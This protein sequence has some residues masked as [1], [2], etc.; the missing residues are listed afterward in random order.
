MARLPHHR[1]EA[2]GAKTTG[3][4]PPIV[5]LR[6]GSQFV[7]VPRA[8]VRPVHPDEID[9]ALEVLL[10]DGS[11]SPRHRQRRITTFKDLAQQESYDLTRQM[12]AMQD[13]KIVH[14]CLFVVNPGA[15]AFIF[16]SKPDPAVEAKVPSELAVQTLSQTCQW[17]RQQG[18]NLLQIIIDPVDTAGRDL[19]TLGGFNRLT[20]L[21]YMFRFCDPESPW[22]VHDLTDGMAWIEYGQATHELFMQV[23]AETYHD[24]LDCPELGPL[25][26]MEDVIAGHK[27]VGRFKPQF[28][29]LLLLNEKPI[30]V[31]LLT[32]SRS[33]NAMELTYMG[34]T[35]PARGKGISKIMLS[36]ALAS[37]GDFGAQFLALA[38][39][40]RN[41]PAYHLYSDFGFTVLQRRTIMYTSLRQS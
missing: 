20:D 35:E 3:P 15:S 22:P 16:I 12:V 10:F 26:D 14:A 4:E 17:A 8:T 18:C 36:Q 19:C 25:R 33:P 9:R 37:A 1:P 28:W 38:V 27:A 21:A 32:P 2:P 7:T 41:C 39:D 31:L 11:D 6:E 24:S 23:I 13:G 29:R 5:P 30:G 34:L 40:C